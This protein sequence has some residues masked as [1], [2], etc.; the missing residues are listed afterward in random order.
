[1]PGRGG[2][3]SSDPGDKAGQSERADSDPAAA[4]RD[5]CLRLLTGRS[6][7]RAELAEALRGKGI[8]A[9]EAEAVLDRYTEVGLLDDVAY[10]DA[11]VRSGHAHRG[12]GRRA[13]RAELRR[14]GVDED[15]AQQA[16]AAVGPEDEERRARELVRRKLRTASGRD[17]VTMVRRL[18]GMLARKGYA[19][20][21]AIRVAREELRADGEAVD[22]SEW[23]DHDE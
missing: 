22:T 3:R 2:R 16:I 19:E 15:V 6:R 9:E 23:P 10:A 13:L 18:A 20:G 17:E 21:L 4:A 1:M 14:K 5:I 12:L 8:P 7:S 11:A